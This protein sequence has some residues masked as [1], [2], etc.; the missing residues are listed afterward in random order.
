MTR[1]QRTVTCDA[2]CPQK[3]CS[4]YQQKMSLPTTTV[5]RARWTHEEIELV[6][7]TMDQPLAVV[8][9]ALGRTYYATA[10]ARS[11]VKHGIF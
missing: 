7:D 1:K 11:R 9:E 6:L 10:L 3:S 8:A 4:H 2:G 5:R